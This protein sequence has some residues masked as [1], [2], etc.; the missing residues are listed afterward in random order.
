MKILTRGGIILVS[1]ILSFGIVEKIT[2]SL[3]PPPLRL[4]R[5]KVLS[6]Y[7]K[8]KEKLVAEE[9]PGNLLY[10]ET[11][12]GIRLRPNVEILVKNAPPE[13]KTPIIWDFS[14]RR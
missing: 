9:K 11:P 1:L 3:F 7:K 8:E 12:L 6:P 2:R 14:T 10:Q 5:V 4:S 13:G